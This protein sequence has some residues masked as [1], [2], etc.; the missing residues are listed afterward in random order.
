MKI[1]QS[2]EVQELSYIN[3]LNGLWGD[4]QKDNSMPIENKIKAK[5]HLDAL[6]K[7]LEKYS[8]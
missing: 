7:I 8:Y 1:Y 5:K 3:L 6:F 4:I 2:D